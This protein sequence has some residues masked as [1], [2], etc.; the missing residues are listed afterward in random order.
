MKIVRAL[1]RLLA[2]FICSLVL[3]SSATWADDVAHS[4]VTNVAKIDNADNA[5]MLISSALVLLMTA[6]GLAL[7]LWRIGEN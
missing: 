1:P 3:L 5:W 6:P 4:P 2:C 7:F